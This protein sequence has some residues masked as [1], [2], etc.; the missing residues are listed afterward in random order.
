MEPR[1]RAQTDFYRSVWEKAGVSTTPPHIDHPW[2]L[3]PHAYATPLKLREGRVRGKLSGYRTGWIFMAPEG[4]L[5]SGKAMPEGDAT[6]F[7]QLGLHG[8]L[9]FL[10][11]HAALASESIV[12]EAFLRPRQDALPWECVEEVVLHTRSR[13]AC[14]VYHLPA[15]PKKP[16][17]LGI[18]LSQTQFVPF[19]ECATHYRGGEK[20]RAGKIGPPTPWIVVVLT[21]V[22]GLILLLALMIFTQLR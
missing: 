16:L 14:I 3:S 6:A 8:L 21:I 4:L 13:R 15:A 20:V 9:H 19:S 18:Q 10:L 17:S 22:I 5:L 1:S 7:L 12:R 11:R 2:A